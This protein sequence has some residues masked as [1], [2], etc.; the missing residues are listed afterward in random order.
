MSHVSR[1]N[2]LRV[3]SICAIHITRVNE[4]S[5]GGQRS[6]EQATFTS[7]TAV[8]MSLSVNESYRY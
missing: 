3:D 4:S 7:A 2:E 6:I 5:L 8:A 1:V